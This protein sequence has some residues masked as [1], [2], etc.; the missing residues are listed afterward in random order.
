MAVEIKASSN[1]VF[2]DGARPAAPALEEH[3]VPLD[4]L[5]QLRLPDR[6][7]ACVLV[8][9][10]CL[11]ALPFQPGLEAAGRGIEGRAAAFL[12][13][14]V[15]QFF[16]QLHPVLVEGIDVPDRALHEDFVFV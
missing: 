10:H 3:A 11:L 13:Q 2:Q 4:N 12:F 15:G 1:A 16:A 6:A 9:G 5:V 7:F 8:F 14:R